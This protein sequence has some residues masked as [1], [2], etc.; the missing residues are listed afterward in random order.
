VM[1]IVIVLCDV[2]PT[3][4]MLIVLLLY[5]VKYLCAECHYVVS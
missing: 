4:V 3:V 1:L 2:L 5:C